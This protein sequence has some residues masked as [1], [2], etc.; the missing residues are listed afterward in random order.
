MTF[1]N[2]DSQ[3][4][5]F[6]GQN[7]TVGRGQTWIVITSPVEGLT[8]V[9]VS[10][11]DIPK[12]NPNCALDDPNACD[13]EFAIK[14]WVNWDARVF[15][16]TWP[17]N[18]G[19]T[20]DIHDD[21]EATFNEISDGGQ[22]VN[23]LDRRELAA[24]DDDN[25]SY[26][27]VDG[28]AP[29]NAAAT[30]FNIAN[31]CELTGNRVL[32][33]SEVRRLR[34]DSPFNIS[35]GRMVWDI[36]DD[37]P[38]VDFWGEDPGNDGD[39]C[40]NGV[41]NAE[42]NG[43]SDDQYWIDSN[44]PG[45]LITTRN[46][47]TIEFDANNNAFDGGVV[48]QNPACTAPCDEDDFI[49]W[50]IA[51]TRPDPGTFFCV[52]VDGNGD[53]NPGG[54]G[55]PDTFS[56]AYQRLLA[57]EI[58]NQNT[59]RVRF[60]DEFGEVCADFTFNKRFV[61]SRLQ[62]IKTTPGAT[63]RTVSE[64]NGGPDVLQNTPIPVKTHTVQVGQTFSYTITVI[65]EGEVRS[66]N[67]RIT[68]TL[69]R[70][71]T[72]FDVVPPDDG[73]PTM[74]N[75]SQAFEFQRDRPAFDPNAVVYALDT[76]DDEAGDAI[77]ECIRGDDGTAAGN[78]YTVPAQCTGI[79][80]DAGTV[81]QAREAAV[82]ASTEDGDQVVFI[83]WF[84]VE[85][86]ARTAVGGGIES[87]DSV[88]VFL[89]ANQNY[90]SLPGTW[91]NIAT[92]TD[93]PENRTRDD[94]AQSFDADTLCHEVREALLDVRK[95]T[96]DA[97]ITAGSNAVFTVEIA[98]NGSA[99]LT[100]VVIA[101]TVDAGLFGEDT[102][103][104]P[105][106][107]RSEDIELASGF[108][109]ATVTINPDSTTFSVDIG[110]LP[111]GGFQR[112][113][114][115]TVPTVRE[116]GTFC[117]RVTARGT[118]PAGTLIETDIACVTLVVAIEMDISNED[119]FI[120]EGGQ[121]QSAKE[122]FTVGESGEDFAYQVIITNQSQFTATGVLVEDLLAPNTGI[123]TF[124]GLRDGFPTRGSVSG[125]SESGFTWDIGTLGPGEFAEIQF[126]AEA[127]RSGEDVNRVVLTSDQLMTPVTNEEPTTITD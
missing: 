109:D 127:E 38:D 83:Q 39:G 87:E 8:D 65:N 104:N 122:E 102:L 53:C 91:C 126:F 10:T 112:V 69:P 97:V 47:A 15:E 77:D 118:N 120:D 54:P 74:R 18:P 43:P 7:V 124:D 84:D 21:P 29:G 14:R 31:A 125:V 86:L 25:P 89:A 71:G 88:E 119:G 111:P 19:P 68:D 9:I 33:M 28:C 64:A 116:E 40:D 70:F 110:N 5:S 96:T 100:N 45:G 12:D 61:T 3:T 36:T 57:A 20:R 105:R 32:F 117:N 50:G 103:G 58:D 2:D 82:S 108:T 24:A 26:P 37:T 59:F 23:I 42:H 56:T 79:T 81:E 106:L 49:G 34:S 41:C 98:N 90:P 63:R 95:T 55:S 78:A 75:G 101:D 72:Q 60:V 114:T 80:T 51:E 13:K 93:G 85:V 67:V 99:T 123:F 11:P 66:Q 16:V 113:F 94:R 52:D 107:L 4:V 6:G 35:R 48:T 73:A 44:N 22:I 17:N 62:I 1:T 121:F 46:R 76:D 92:V 30:A 27:G 115:L